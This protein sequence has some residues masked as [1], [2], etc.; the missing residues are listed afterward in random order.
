MAD[1]LNTSLREE[2]IKYLDNGHADREAEAMAFLSLFTKSDDDEKKALAPMFEQLSSKYEIDREE[3]QH[4]EGSV[5]M[6]DKNTLDPYGY[7]IE[8]N[9]TLGK[10]IS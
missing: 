10:M 4:L 5:R 1:D 3:W 6:G 7:G 9:S 8:M 2:K